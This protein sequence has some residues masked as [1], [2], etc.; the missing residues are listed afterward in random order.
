MHIDNVWARRVADGA[1][2]GMYREVAREIDGP[3][4]PGIFTLLKQ[5]LDQPPKTSGS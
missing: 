4:A 3:P 2:K 1:E 5:A